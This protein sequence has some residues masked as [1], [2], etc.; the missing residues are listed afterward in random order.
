MEYVY[1]VIETHQCGD[2]VESYLDIF[3]ELSSARE[4][5]DKIKEELIEESSANTLVDAK[6]IAE[7]GYVEN[8][9]CYLDIDGYEIIYIDKDEGSK[10]IIKLET[11]KIGE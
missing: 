6:T 9:L 10:K 3:K 7:E 2:E 5:F 1:A 11:H 8:A 4:H